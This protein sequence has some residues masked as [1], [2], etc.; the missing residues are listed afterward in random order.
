VNWRV[1]LRLICWVRGHDWWAIKMRETPDSWQYLE[2]SKKFG[3]WIVPNAYCKLCHA[4]SR[5]KTAKYKSVLT[6]EVI[7]GNL[8]E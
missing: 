3:T 2:W 5:R 7:I 4:C 6:G 8:E 1:I